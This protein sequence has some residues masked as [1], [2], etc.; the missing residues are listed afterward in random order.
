MDTYTEIPIEKSVLENVK[1]YIRD[2][3]TDYMN[4]KYQV[5]KN[6]FSDITKN[7]SPTHFWN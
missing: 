1:T 5:Y 7:F 4:I 6:T 2:L 3:F